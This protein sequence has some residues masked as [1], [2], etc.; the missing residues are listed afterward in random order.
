VAEIVQFDRT[1][2]TK[3]VVGVF[4]RLLEDFEISLRDSLLSADPKERMHAQRMFLDVF[5]RLLNYKQFMKALEA[6]AREE[7][8]GET[9][10]SV[11]RRLVNEK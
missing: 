7:A 1:D 11:I 6:R 3:S 10:V 2:L 5:G 4:A 9:V 8:D